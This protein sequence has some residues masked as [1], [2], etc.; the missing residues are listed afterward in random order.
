MKLYE[1]L[2]LNKGAV[3][4]IGSGGKTTMMLTLARELSLLGKTIVTT[5]TH[6]RPPEGLP[7]IEKPRAFSQSCVCMGSFNAEG[8]LSAPAR[9]EELLP[10]CDYLL[11]EADGSRGLPIKAHLDHEPVIADCSDRTILVIGASGFNRPIGKVTHRAERFCELAGTTDDDIVTPKVLSRV[12]NREALFDSI[13]INQAETDEQR[14]F[15]LELKK[16]V[17][18]PVFAGE[19]QKEEWTCVF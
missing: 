7:L 8:K 6:I 4:I 5:T 16:L 3:S 11:I 15:A 19:F 9:M 18:V 17:A 1:L 13:F 10:L 14:D 2:K 12:L